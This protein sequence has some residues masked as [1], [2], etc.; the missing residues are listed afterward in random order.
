[1]TP[2][3]YETFLRE[4]EDNTRPRYVSIYHAVRNIPYGGIGERNPLAVLEN[5]R[6]S[7]S[8][9]HVL[10]R[11]LL[12]AAGYEAEVIT[13]YTHLNKTIPLLSSF[14]DDLSLMVRDEEIKDYHHF[15]RIRIDGQW[16]N[17]DATWHDALRDHG[18]PVNMNWNGTGHTTVAASTIEE[19]PAVEDLAV[20]KQELI[21]ALTPEA[22]EKR[23]QFFEKLTSWIETKTPS[24]EPRTTE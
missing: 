17:L 10:L 16:L 24:S 19:Y 12:R 9:K 8:G 23:E 6:G 22:R 13:I 5:R 15:V 14:P 1:M 20:F 4:I 2:K 7:C 3:I 18:F 11:D 21:A